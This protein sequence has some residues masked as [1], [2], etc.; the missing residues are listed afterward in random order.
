MT[1]ATEDLEVLIERCEHAVL[2][3]KAGRRASFEAAIQAG[4]LLVQIKDRIERGDWLTHLEKL[5]IPE[6]TAQRWMRIGQWSINVST[7]IELGGIRAR[8]RRLRCSYNA[9]SVTAT[10]G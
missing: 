5:Q 8:C 10:A 1:L 9:G 3:Y 6:R 4:Q 2:R 7:A